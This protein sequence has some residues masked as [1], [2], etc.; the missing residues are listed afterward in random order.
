MAKNKVRDYRFEP[1]FDDLCKN[2]EKN[3]RNLH[4]EISEKHPELSVSSKIVELVDNF[5]PYKKAKILQFETVNGCV[6]VILGGK[7][8]LYEFAAKSKI[9]SQDL[10]RYV[11]PHFEDKRNRAFGE[12][13]HVTE[14]MNSG[15]DA[16]W[17]HT[18]SIEDMFDK[19]RIILLD[20]EHDHTC[21]LALDLTEEV[22]EAIQHAADESNLTFDK[23]LEEIIIKIANDETNKTIEDFVSELKENTNE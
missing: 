19:L 20:E 1:N 14:F 7:D 5:G 10:Y 18:D 12:R 6:E 23:M 8:K 15:K 2:L 4:K 11:H 13:M 21:V 3:F 22:V 9:H 17:Y 16:T